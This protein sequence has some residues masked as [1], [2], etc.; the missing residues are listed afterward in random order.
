MS[1]QEEVIVTSEDKTVAQGERDASFDVCIVGCGVAGL[2]AALNLPRHLRIAMLS[3]E[4]VA[5]CDSML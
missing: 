4:D 3:K 5:S 2:Y 1:A